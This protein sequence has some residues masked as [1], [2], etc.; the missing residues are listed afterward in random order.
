MTE[1]CQN[2]HWSLPINAQQTKCCF[3]PPTAILL[4]VKRDEKTGVVIGHESI[5]IHPIMGPQ[6]FCAHHREREDAE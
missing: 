6:D 4:G 5:S 3:A 2:C 1:T